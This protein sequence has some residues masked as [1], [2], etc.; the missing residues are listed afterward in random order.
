MHQ[1]KNE[2]A[3]GGQGTRRID[4]ANSCALASETAKK[5]LRKKQKNWIEPVQSRL[6]DLT[7]G[8]RNYKM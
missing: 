6:G 5:D 3:E 7:V 4:K 1:R 2:T 8:D